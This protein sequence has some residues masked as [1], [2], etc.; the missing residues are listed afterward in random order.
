MMCPRPE[1]CHHCREWAQCWW[2]LPA[3]RLCAECY[4]HVTGQPPAVAQ[5]TPVSPR[6][7]MDTPD[8]PGGPSSDFEGAVA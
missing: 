8:L 4:E 3:W 1:R 5:V 6:R 7:C 2:T